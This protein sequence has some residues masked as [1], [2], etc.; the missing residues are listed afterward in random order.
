MES[1]VRLSLLFFILSSLFFDLGK[2]GP[3]QIV[4][5]M[6]IEDLSSF[7]NMNMVNTALLEL[8]TSTTEN[9]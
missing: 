2:D 8:R 5:S 4:M 1:E 3:L 6:F 7:D 9:S